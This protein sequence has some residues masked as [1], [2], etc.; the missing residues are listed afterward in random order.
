MRAGV[1]FGHQQSRWHPKMEPFI[2]GARNGVHIIDL[3]KT[4]VQLEKAAAFLSATAAKGGKALFLGTKPQTKKFVQTAAERAGMPFVTERWLG[5]TFTNFE[6]IRRMMKRLAELKKQIETGELA[7][8][9][10]KRELLDFSREAGEL[11]KKIGGIAD[12]MEL[13]RA[14]VVFDVRGELTAIREAKKRKIPVVAVCDT[15]VNPGPVDY[16]IPGNDDAIK[17]VALFTRVLADA[18][19]E[20]KKQYVAPAPSVL[21]GKTMRRVVHTKPAS[22]E[23]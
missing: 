10:T 22:A 17:A 3:E 20:G 4:V 2:F 23:K 21:A 12:M 9:Y 16:V 11:Q 7:K 14:I 5:G 1:H 6:E 15:N 13:P 19:L 18:V 8:K